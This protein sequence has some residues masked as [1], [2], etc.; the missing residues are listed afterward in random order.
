MRERTRKVS[1]S[2]SFHFRQFSLST[3]IFSAFL[4]F[5]QSRVN[6]NN[7]YYPAY[8]YQ[9]HSFFVILSLHL[10]NRLHAVGYSVNAYIYVCMFVCIYGM[11]EFDGNL[12][13]SC[14]PACAQRMGLMK[15]CYFFRVDR[16]TNLP[17]E[18]KTNKQYVKLEEKRISII[19]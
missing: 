16:R 9:L 19:L 4:S 1:P 11:D 6:R 10:G 5:D 18:C 12:F 17:G 14:I 3:F 2:T 15:E 7:V 13:I 8:L